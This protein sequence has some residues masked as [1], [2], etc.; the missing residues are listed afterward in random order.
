MPVNRSNVNILYWNCQSNDNEKKFQQIFFEILKENKVDI[1][2]LDESI[3][4]PNDLENNISHSLGHYTLIGQGL[5]NGKFGRLQIFS[6][7]SKLHFDEK[8]KSKR[9]VNFHFKKKFDLCFIHFKSLLYATEYDKLKSDEETINN[10]Y[11][12]KRSYEKKFLVGDFNASPYSKTML[13]SKF[14]NTVR[15]GEEHFQIKRQNLT[16]RKRINPSW[17]F[18]VENPNGVYGTIPNNKSKDDNL[19]MELFDQVI[20]DDGLQQYYESKSFKIISK[21]GKMDLLDDC[22]RCPYSDHLPIFFR[23]KNL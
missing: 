22:L 19:G 5:V 23:L 11:G 13:K 17:S 12:K 2:C 16:K 15:I 10:I 9:F 14:L 8:D 18:F 1:F 6:R 3:V 7:I 21:V 20:F 4:D